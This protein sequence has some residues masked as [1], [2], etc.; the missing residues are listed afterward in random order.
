LYR[1]KPGETIPT[2]LKRIVR[3]QLDSAIG[4]LNGQGKNRTEAV[5]EARKSLKKIRA[6]LRLLKK[7]LG[8]VYSVETAQ[9]RLRSRQLSEIRDAAARIETIDA[10][11]EK[12]AP[13]LGVDA[14]SSIR[15]ALVARREEFEQAADTGGVFPSVAR[16]LRTVARRVKGWPLQTDGFAALAPG[17]KKAFRRGREAFLCAREDPSPENLHAW[18]RRV[19]DLWYDLRLLE[20]LRP[21]VLE[22]YAGDLKDLQDWLGEYQNLAMLRDSFAAQPELC[23]ERDDIDTFLRVAGEHQAG[24][25]SQALALGETVYREST[26]RFLRAVE[27]SWLAHFPDSPEPASPA[28]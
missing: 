26:R 16:A 21:A 1:F 18:R 25:R 28:K 5:H 11:R 12:F 10:L 6:V 7:D 27:K 2:G 19:K 24:L 15:R 22:N 13:E 8:P 17:I 20:P 4:Q 9:L 14:F 3:E 23:G